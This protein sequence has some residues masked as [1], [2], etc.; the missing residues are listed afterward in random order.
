MPSHSR[1]VLF[2]RA[3]LRLWVPVALVA[4][5]LLTSTHVHAQESNV[6]EDGKIWPTRWVEQ[7]LV[8]TPGFTRIA[9][10]TL[11]ITLTRRQ[12]FE[13]V[14]SPLEVFYGYNDKLT[15]GLL[16]DTGL[17][18]SGPCGRYEDMRFAGWYRL[19]RNQNA[20]LIATGALDIPSF[21]NSFAM[22]LRAGLSVKA[23]YKKIGVVLAP[24]VYL[25]A[26]GRSS[27]TDRLRLPIEVGWQFSPKLVGKLETGWLGPLSGFSD[28]VEIPVG[29]GVDYRWTDRFE[30]GGEFLFENFFGRGAT[31]D[32]RVLYLRASVW[33]ELP[34]LSE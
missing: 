17:C 32:R 34:V 5:A 27:I 11:A 8:L 12:A 30:V 2:R 14:A 10:N 31:F 28:A 16:H 9:G 13:P 21:S 6:S 7:P 26:F 33:F 19:L 25:G 3:L 1:P 22:G 20:E 29:L 18:W 24:E 23:F 4:S 15:L